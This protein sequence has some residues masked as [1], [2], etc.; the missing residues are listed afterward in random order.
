VQSS[1]RRRNLPKPANLTQPVQSIVEMGAFSSSTQSAGTSHGAPSS[2]API[3]LDA[4][5]IRGKNPLARGLSFQEGM[6]GDGGDRTEC[7]FVPLSGGPETLLPS[8][9]VVGK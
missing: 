8:L 3:R 6:I 4:R 5:P 2:A 1:C 9:H 7:F